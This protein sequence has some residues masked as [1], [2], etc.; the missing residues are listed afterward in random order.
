MDALTLFKRLRAHYME[1]FRAHLDEMVRQKGGEAVIVE[2]ILEAGPDVPDDPPLHDPVWAPAPPRFARLDMAVADANGQWFP[3]RVAPEEM[4]AFDPVEFDWKETLTIALDSFAWD[5]AFVSIEP[6]DAKT[7]QALLDWF[8]AE[9]A[10]DKRP[11][12]RPLNVVHSLE[13][14]GK[15][16]FLVDLGTAHASAVERLFDAAR[17]AGATRLTIATLGASDGHAHEH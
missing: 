4:L 5:D 9:A 13:P 3:Y 2:P 14:L 1:A 16:G 8:V 12:A 10:E 11:G 6:A 15:G 17:N 7:T